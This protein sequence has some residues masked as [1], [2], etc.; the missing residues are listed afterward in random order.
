MNMPALEQFGAQPPVELLRQYFDH[1]NWYDLKDTSKITL[2]DLQIIAAMGP[3]GGGRNAVTPRFL[4]HFNICSINAFSD[5]TMVRIFS[6]VVAFYLKIND[7]PPEYFTVG[8]Q[9][10]AATMEVYKKAMQN[11]LP[12][13]AKS[14][15]TFNLR[16]FSRVVQG[17]LLLRKESLGNK[18]TMTRLFVHEVL[19][20][21]YD[22]L[23]DAADRAW[24]YQLMN[25][26]VKEHFRESFEQV[27]DHLKKDKQLVEEDMC[28]LLFGDYMAPV[29]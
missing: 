21:Y 27:F 29:F 26:I 3:P 15:Y 28:N 4:R 7:F 1:G 24:L 23:V 22:R 2:V 9:I 19:R 14:H 8:N 10:V 5:D 12:T 20:V 18:G 13:P 11:L 16:D 25:D 6:N 17:C